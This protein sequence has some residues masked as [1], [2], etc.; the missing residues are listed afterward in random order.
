MANIDPIRT[1]GEF[2]QA[3][4]DLHS[5]VSRFAAS[6]GNFG[7]VVAVGVFDASTAGNLLAW[8]TITS[9]TVNDGDTLSFAIG[10]IDITLT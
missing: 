2:V 1:A 8:T 9:A 3:L 10:D 6:G 4:K 7:N 5:G